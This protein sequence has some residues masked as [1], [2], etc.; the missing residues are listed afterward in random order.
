M[1]LS[2]TWSLHPTPCPTRST[3]GLRGRALLAT[4]VYSLARLG[5]MVGMNVEDYYQQ[6]KRW[7]LRL[8]E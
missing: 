5:A 8:P 2:P 6:G 3:S 1:F 7:R 4:T